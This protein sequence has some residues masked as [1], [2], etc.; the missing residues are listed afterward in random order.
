MV[1]GL[2]TCQDSHLTGKPRAGQGS[3]LRVA[4]GVPWGMGGDP[5]AVLTDAASSSLLARPCFLRRRDVSSCACRSGHSPFTVATGVV[6]P[7]KPPCCSSCCWLRL[8]RMPIQHAVIYREVVDGKE[9]QT[10]RA[11][12]L[13]AHPLEF[14]VCER[15]VLSG[16][17]VHSTLK[18]P[19]IRGVSSD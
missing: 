6:V 8:P 17:R 2:G 15:N 1:E 7:A 16:S 5:R 9:S 10:E 14:E 4:Q 19:Q 12:V 13:C 11:I 18:H 3:P